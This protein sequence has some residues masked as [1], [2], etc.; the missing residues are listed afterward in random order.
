MVRILG[1]QCCGPGSIPGKG[2]EI[3]KA[4]RRSQK[5]KQQKGQKHFPPYSSYTPQTHSPQVMITH[6]TRRC[7]PH[8]SP[9]A[10]ASLQLSWEPE[11]PGTSWVG[12]QKAGELNYRDLFK[13]DSVV[14]LKYVHK[15][16]D[17]A[18]F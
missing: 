1:F 4:T 10:A 3:P 9:Q 14:I 11:F 13:R 8:C 7:C 2:T 5:K 17:T 15:F 16:F 6:Q 18:S 12:E